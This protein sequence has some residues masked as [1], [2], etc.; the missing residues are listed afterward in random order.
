MNFVSLFITV[1]YDISATALTGGL[2]L[3]GGFIS[4][5]ERNTFQSEDTPPLIGVN[6]DGVSDILTVAARCISGTSTAY[7][8]F[9]WKEVR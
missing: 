3:E 8:S 2:S 5:R 9:N 1:E 4:V 7:T 6:V